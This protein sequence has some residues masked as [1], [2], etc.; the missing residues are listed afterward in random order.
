MPETHISEWARTHNVAMDP[1]YASESR[2]G[3]TR[4]LGADVP[5]L[6]RRDLSVF[7]EEGWDRTK[8]KLI[9]ERWIDAVKS[10]PKSVD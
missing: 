9:Y 4:A 8:D 2:E 1:R 6:T 5:G 7:D 3:G 10:L